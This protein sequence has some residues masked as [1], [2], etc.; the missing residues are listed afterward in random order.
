MLPFPGGAFVLGGALLLPIRVNP[1]DLDRALLDRCGDRS[2][3]RKNRSENGA[4]HPDC[5]RK[6]GDRV[7]IVLD[8][9]AADVA[10]VDEPLDRVHE[11]FAG[12]LERFLVGSL[13][14]GTPPD[15]IAAT[16]LYT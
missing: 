7:R 12:H 2:N 5:E 11:L 16:R 10:F 1:L 8:D 14:H 13:S 6:L 3:G 9:Y 4:N 15:I